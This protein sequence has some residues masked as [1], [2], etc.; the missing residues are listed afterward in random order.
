MSLSREHREQLLFAA[1][2]KIG[3]K[4]LERS[5]VPVGQHN[6]EI[7]ATARF[8]ERRADDVQLIAVGELALGADQPSTKKVGPKAEDVLAAVWFLMPADLRATIVG[9][10]SST[11]SDTKDLPPVPGLVAKDVKAL[12]ERLSDREAT[13]KAGNL[14]YTFDLLSQ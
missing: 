2:G 5:V 6:V 7:H 12:L 14:V 10:L 11:Y 4:R 9:L 3:E 8:G 1:I 13:T